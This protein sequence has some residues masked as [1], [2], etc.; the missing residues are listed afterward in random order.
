M[1]T[2]RQKTPVSSFTSQRDPA[3]REENL[4]QRLEELLSAP[5]L[6][7]E[8]ARAGLMEASEMLKEQSGRQAVLTA[9]YETATEIIDV[10]VSG[11]VLQAAVNR[12]KVL[13]SSDLAYLALYDPQSRGTRVT[14]TVGAVSP[15][16]GSLHVHLGAGMGGK[17]SQLR[18]PFFTPDYLVDD[19]L[20]HLPR[21]DQGI[22]AEGVRGMIG[23]P[24]IAR[25]QFLGALFVADRVVRHYTESDVSCLQGLAA[26]IAVALENARLFEREEASLK[27]TQIAYESLNARLAASEREASIHRRIVA[28]LGRNGSLDELSAVVEKELNATAGFVPASGQKVEDPIDENAY[29]SDVGNPSVLRLMVRARSPL[30]GGDRRILERVVQA[31]ETLLLRRNVLTVEKALAGSALFQRLLSGG[32]KIAEARELGEEIAIDLL[33]PCTIA[34]FRANER[35]PEQMMAFVRQAFGAIPHLI[36]QQ[37]GAALALF[38]ET[39]G[40]HLGRIQEALNLL[41]GVP[42]AIG[43]ATCAEPV[44]NAGDA[45]RKAVNSVDLVV[46]LGKA[47]DVTADLSVTPEALLLRSAEPGDVEAYIETALGQVLA[48]DGNRPGEL[49]ATMRAYF[50]A[51]LN[52]AKAAEIL[53]IHYK[54]VMQRLDRISKVSGIDFK[55]PKQ[56]FR[57][58]IALFML[59]MKE[60]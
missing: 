40:S 47:G 27:Q 48:Y 8:R 56:M 12:A 51:G 44:V 39:N 23:V 10:H 45:A 42:V 41:A 1:K 50:D 59:G 9:L 54:T 60:R 6:D 16:F 19:R 35:S 37:S 30:T 49:V 24:L 25:N 53:R 31:A 52:A 57:V 46:V 2:P 3:R 29:S 4:P 20:V 13:L 14:A 43:T 22:K 5:D 58:Q 11:E 17:V 26:L 7:L 36:S 18:E 32:G 34:A 33:R 28:I 38:Q 21:V 15:G 55:D